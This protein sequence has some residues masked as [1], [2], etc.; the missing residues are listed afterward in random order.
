MKA[1]VKGWNLVLG[2][3]ALALLFAATG[4]RSVKQYRF[5]SSNLEAWYPLDESAPDPDSLSGLRVALQADWVT[6]S[7][8]GQAVADRI[9]DA[10][11]DAL[12]GIVYGDTEPGDREMGAS[13]SLA[14]ATSGM[15]LMAAVEAAEPEIAS[16]YG[17]QLADTIL[18]QHPLGQAQ[19][20]AW[21]QALV[22]RYL[23]EYRQDLGGLVADIEAGRFSP[24]AAAYELEC[25][26]LLE[27]SEKDV[28]VWKT[29]LYLYTGGAHGSQA[30]RYLNVNPKTGAE[31]TLSEV[32]KPEMMDT[33]RDRVR[34]KLAESAESRDIFDLA[35]VELPSQFRLGGDA[36]VFQYQV[37]EI[38][39]YVSGPIAV[40]L[41][42]A[43]LA[44]CL[45]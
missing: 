38:A 11:L 20:E 23:S 42:K 14:E 24:N 45:R 18:L 19:P 13:E 15:E 1:S 43:E 41:T 3:L 36:I 31:I 10:L 21:M 5:V 17:R 30:V 34:A 6:K 2:G 9:N 28:L 37:Y 4:C 40:S 44:D 22:N 33:V 7:P 12:C 39:P 27:V 26:Q 35:S 16:T 8:Y 29:Q 25:H 32:I